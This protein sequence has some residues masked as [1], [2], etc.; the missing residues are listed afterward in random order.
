MCF[1]IDGLN[2]KMDA[3]TNDYILK[4]G[5]SMSEQNNYSNSTPLDFISSTDSLNN[6]KLLEI[7]SRRRSNSLLNQQL[8]LDSNDSQ[9]NFTKT[10]LG[11]NFQHSPNLSIPHCPTSFSP[12]PRFPPPSSVNRDLFNS[13]LETTCIVSS[14]LYIFVLYNFVYHI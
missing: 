9:L 13:G 5:L 14:Y 8:L 2:Y 3:S 1:F 11:H 4:N 6:E 12:L 7:C 10:S